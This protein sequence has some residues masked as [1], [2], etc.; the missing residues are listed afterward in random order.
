MF[1]IA[2]LVSVGLLTFC[3]AAA[4]Q[5]T[6][7]TEINL[8]TGAKFTA[9]GVIDWTMESPM[10]TYV[11]KA[12]SDRLH[13][14][15]EVTAEKNFKIKAT[16]TRIKIDF[17]LGMMGD[18]AYD[19]EKAEDEAKIKTNPLV[20]RYAM[21]GDTYTFVL[22]PE[23]KVV[24]EIEG[25]DKIKEK[26]LS[27]LPKE[28]GGEGEGADGSDMAASIREELEKKPLKDEFKKEIELTFAVPS[29]DPRKVGESWTPEKASYDVPN[30]GDA[31][32]E[33][34]K[35]TLAKKEG[36]KAFF[37]FEAKLGIKKDEGQMAAIGQFLTISKNTIKK[38]TEFDLK[39]AFMAKQTTDIDIAMEAAKDL[40]EGMESLAGMKITMKGKIVYEI[41]DFKAPG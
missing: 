18:T 23:G 20:A 16:F 26:I 2:G 8:A 7:K 24:G 1:R 36:D 27:R 3:L 41:T 29:K 9:K 39:N 38:T 33:E 22:S 4:A 11:L 19:S 30:L 15:L 5:D 34:A 25:L 17:K 40:P 31:D 12:E 37:S 32:L 35:M 28:E 10:G 6:V 21:K 13:E 14:V